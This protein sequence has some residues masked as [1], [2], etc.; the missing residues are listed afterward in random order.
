LYAYGSAAIEVNPFIGLYYL[1]QQPLV[2][3]LAK[4]R[5]DP[6]VWTPE[7]KGESVVHVELATRAGVFG[8]HT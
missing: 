5:Y 7:P 8:P 6:V 1:A 2:Y 4:M 3:A